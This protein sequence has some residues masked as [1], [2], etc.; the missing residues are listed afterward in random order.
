MIW[1]IQGAVR[2]GRGAVE[3]F[4]FCLYSTIRAVKHFLSSKLPCIYISNSIVQ[5]PIDAGQIRHGNSHANRANRRF[6]Q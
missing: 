2:C 3:V 1:Y 4:T 6:L 5:W